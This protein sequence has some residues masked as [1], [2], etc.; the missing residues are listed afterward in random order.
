MIAL[1][2][3]PAGIYMALIQAFPVKWL[4]YHYFIKKPVNWTIFTGLLIWTVVLTTQQGSFPLW[5]IIPLI[6]SGIGVALLYK[7]HQS[8]MFKAVDFPKMVDDIKALPLKDDMQMA[9]IE[10]EG[11]TKCYPLDYVILHH[12]INDK[13]NDK[14]V[15]LTYCA[16]CRSIIPFDVTDIGPL[17][18]GSFKDG[19]MIVADKKT[20]TF[21]QQ[22]S[23]QSI[24]GKLHPSELTMIPFQVLTWEEVKNLNLI[25]QIAH[26]TKDDFREFRLPLP[27][28]GLW[29]RIMNSE[30]TP[31]LSKN[32]RDKT[33]PARTRVVGTIDSSLSVEFVYL[34][35][36]L[37]EKKV[38]ENSENK[39][40]LICNSSG[41]NGFKTILNNKEL[42]IELSNGKLIDKASGTH[43]DI[44]GKYINGEITNNLEMIALS[45]E[46]W[47][48]WKEFHPESKLIR[49]E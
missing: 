41:V 11:I 15:S 6:I 34:K 37:E 4:Y 25:P 49:L 19:N 14:I 13:F 46:Y 28:P 3:G 9:V 39:F 5:T 30:A 40:V 32:N 1:A 27:I 20:T 23:F 17:F 26:V 2:I 42:N 31:G 33:F 38:V 35:R 21:F 29:K 22:S 45:E 18:V 24:I 36:E 12:I 43:W 7:M 47:F 16:H 48:S 10:F 44:R 8:L